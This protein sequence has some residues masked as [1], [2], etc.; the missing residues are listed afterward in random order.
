M[1]TPQ[2]TWGLAW[3]FPLFLAAL[4]LARIFGLHASDRTL[5]AVID[6]AIVG[7]DPP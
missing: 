4:S 7:G 6:R 1:I 5:E 2:P 3:W